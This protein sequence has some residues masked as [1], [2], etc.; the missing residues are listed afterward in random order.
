MIPHHLSTRRCSRSSS[1]FPI[2]R[3]TEH[4][5]SVN[6]SPSGVR[7]GEKGPRTGHHV[8]AMTKKH[9]SSLAMSSLAMRRCSPFF[10]LR[11]ADLAPRAIRHQLRD[12]SIRVPDPGTGDPQSG[13]QQAL[14]PLQCSFPLDRHRAA[15]KNSD[16]ERHGPTMTDTTHLHLPNPIKG[17]RS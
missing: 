8:R 2:L 4:R 17:V 6:I 5:G 10:A 15:A 9:T 13:S 1:I 14:L 12:R 16:E 11:S 3:R 7:S